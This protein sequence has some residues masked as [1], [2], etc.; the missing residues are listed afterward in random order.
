[1]AS[2]DSLVETSAK[3]TRELF[4]T[5]YTVPLPYNASTGSD[6]L[7]LATKAGITSRIRAEYDHVRE[8]PPALAAKQKAAS[9]ARKKA[10]TEPS[11]SDTAKMI[12]GIPASKSVNGGSSTGACPAKARYERHGEC[13]WACVSA[14]E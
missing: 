13:E 3:R 8:L 12:E 14:I 4:G 9:Q 5:D 1:M 6:P 2:A 7:S 10:K 11:N